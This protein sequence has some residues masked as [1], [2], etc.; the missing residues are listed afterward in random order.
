MIRN[1]LRSGTS[2]DSAFINIH[3][4]LCDSKGIKSNVKVELSHC[5]DR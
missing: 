1:N 5:E 3:T 2:L 4:K